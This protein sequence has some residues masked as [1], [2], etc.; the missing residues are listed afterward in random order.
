MYVRALLSPMC[1]LWRAAPFSGRA[2][3][4]G[5]C[6]GRPCHLVAQKPR[7][8]LVVLGACAARGAGRHAN[9]RGTQTLIALRRSGCVCLGPPQVSN[10]RGK[11][12]DGV[13][14]APAA[15]RTRG[16][17]TRK[18]LGRR[19][20]GLGLGGRE[21]RIAGPRRGSWVQLLVPAGVAADR[22]PV[23]AADIPHEEHIDRWLSQDRIPL[24]GMLAILGSNGTLYAAHVNEKVARGWVRHKPATAAD[25]A[26]AALAR[27]SGAGGTGPAAEREND[28]AGLV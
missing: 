25:A 27:R 26:A 13:A 8:G 3:L 4:Q 20:L 16:R 14:V 22:Q 19:A 21:L 23:G 18:A 17:G 7:D 2:W 24:R 9:K 28:A 10:M 15:A 6:V 5:L 11:V 12:P 1:L